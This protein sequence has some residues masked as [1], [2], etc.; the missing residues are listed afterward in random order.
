M[1]SFRRFI[2][3][4][5]KLKKRNVEI[6]DFIWVDIDTLNLGW[7]PICE[8]SNE[9]TDDRT[10]CPAVGALMK[11]ENGKFNTSIKY[12]M[13]IEV[14]DLYEKYKE[15][16]FTSERWKDTRYYA[17][18]K[19]Y[20]DMGLD[21]DV[22]T[23]QWILYKIKRLTALFDSIKKDGYRYLVE[24]KVSILDKPMASYYGYKREMSGYEIWNGAHR[25]ACVY[26]LDYKKIKVLLLELKRTK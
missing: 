15:E 23:D 20:R 5:I 11:D 4:D 12:S 25:A 18:H 10:L 2:A 14:L 13:H 22:R 19:A 17:L 21:S 7:W 3:K 16:L 24:N 6:K 8:M 9:K 26:K 1:T